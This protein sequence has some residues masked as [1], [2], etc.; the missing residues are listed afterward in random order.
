MPVVSPEMKTMHHVMPCRSRVTSTR[1]FQQLSW[2]APPPGTR[3]VPTSRRSSSPWGPTTSP[4]WR[5]PR[6]PQLPPPSLPSRDAQGAFCP[7]VAQR[8]LSTGQRMAETRSFFM[9]G[10]RRPLR[11]QCANAAEPASVTI[12]AFV[13][14]TSVCWRSAVCLPFCYRLNV[15]CRHIHI[16]NQILYSSIFGA[17][18]KRMIHVQAVSTVFATTDTCEMMSNKAV[19]LNVNLSTFLW[20]PIVGIIRV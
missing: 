14:W 16:D 11:L 6:E 15:K 5:R 1:P 10:T 20:N 13:N 19:R 8:I 12:C 17:Q 7:S 18:W 4:R 9:N 2:I 3:T